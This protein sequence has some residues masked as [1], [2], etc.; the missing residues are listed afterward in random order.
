MRREPCPQPKLASRAELGDRSWGHITR[1]ERYRAKQQKKAICW[2]FVSPLTDSN[3]R[4]LLTIN[5]RTVAVRTD[6]QGATALAGMVRPNRHRV[7]VRR[8]IP[9]RDTQHYCS[10][11]E[12]S[13]PQT[14]PAAPSAATTQADHNPLS[15]TS[16]HNTS[17]CC[18]VGWYPPR[19]GGPN[20]GC[21]G[22][23]TSCRVRGTCSSSRANV[24]EADHDR[25]RY[26]YGL[27]AGRARSARC[28]PSPLGRRS[29]FR[30]EPRN[31]SAG[32]ASLRG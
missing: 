8:L 1:G 4:P 10:R 31:P 13:T 24:V 21:H 11:H 28:A 5:L 25:L 19:H 26:R 6:E 7:P 17:G 23:T 29:C 15:S 32:W 9:P 30:S 16:P 27:C 20:S 12:R 22:Q 2:P 18:D 3:R 14:A